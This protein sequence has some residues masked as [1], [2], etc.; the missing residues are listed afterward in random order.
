M[1]N[2]E[3]KEFTDKELLERIEEE[4]SMLSRLKMNHVVSPLDNPHKITYVR[5]NIA[6]LKTE[7][8]HRELNNQE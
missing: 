4:Q 7:L 2:T 8:R 6:K 1:K 5:R 3:I